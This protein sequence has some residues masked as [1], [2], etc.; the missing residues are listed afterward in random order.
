MCVLSKF[1]GG[2]QIQLSVMLQYLINAKSADN[3]LLLDKVVSNVT[4]A[5]NG[6]LL[7]RKFETAST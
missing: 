5:D 2:G 4:K 1:L 3:C 6:L 7:D